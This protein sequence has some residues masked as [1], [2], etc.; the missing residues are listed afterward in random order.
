MNRLTRPFSFV[1]RFS[2]EEVPYVPQSNEVVEA[3]F[4]DN[5]SFFVKQNGDVY[6]AGTNTRRCSGLGGSYPDTYTTVGGNPVKITYFSSNNISIT[7]VATTSWGTFFLSSTGVLY[8]AGDSQYVTG[9]AALFPTAV[10][11]SYSS[12]NGVTTFYNS[13]MGNV[14]NIRFSKIKSDG[15]LFG[16]IT[17]TGALGLTRP[18]T[19]N[20]FYIFKGLEMQ[21]LQTTST[22]TTSTFSRNIVDFELKSNVRGALYDPVVLA[23]DTSGLLWKRGGNEWGGTYSTYYNLKSFG[24]YWSNYQNTLGL[25]EGPH[26]SYVW[27]G[28]LDTAT[29]TGVKVTSIALGNYYALVTTSNGELWCQGDSS[30]FGGS[31][32]WYDS[33]T[34]INGNSPTQFVAYNMTFNL[35]SNTL[36]FSNIRSIAGGLVTP[37]LVTRVGGRDI[38]KHGANFSDQYNQHEWVLE[39]QSSGFWSIE[40]NWSDTFKGWAIT[41]N[42]WITD[43]TG[44]T[45]LQGYNQPYSTSTSPQTDYGRD[46]LSSFL[47]GGTNYNPATTF[48][49]QN[50]QQNNSIRVPVSSDTTGLAANAISHINT[51]YNVD[52]D[53]LR[54]KSNNA[55]WYHL[56]AAPTFDETAKY[57]APSSAGDVVPKVFAGNKTFGFVRNRVLYVWGMNRKGQTGVA[58]TDWVVGYPKTVTLP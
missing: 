10:P 20:G 51:N 53:F 30:R 55:I 38:V 58:S 27:H 45:G 13:N 31:G 34:K 41:G 18:E 49:I 46:H 2:T 21:S 39:D 54:L 50:A 16:A 47:N 6:F 11:S 44:Y 37:Y 28:S 26:A 33:Y 29:L 5:A 14:S 25:V 23:I 56:Y 32:S 17:T 42:H 57:A 4:G 19:T 36:G 24:F 1:S 9:A 3:S 43:G 48:D 35:V 22:S 15:Y 52:G 7:Q 40:G 8:Y 12:L